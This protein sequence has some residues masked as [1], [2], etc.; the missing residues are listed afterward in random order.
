MQGI[1]NVAAGTTEGRAVDELVQPR[2]DAGVVF[3]LVLAAVVIVLWTWRVRHD[4]DLRML[5]M[6]SGVFLLGLFALR[7]AH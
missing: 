7:A 2:T 5:A 3:Q 6:G 1:G 4:R